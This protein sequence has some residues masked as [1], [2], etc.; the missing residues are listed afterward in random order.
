V[1]SDIRIAFRTL[2]YQSLSVAVPLHHLLFLPT[3]KAPFRTLIAARYI[4]M[5]LSYHT[6]AAKNGTK[7]EQ[8]VRE[9]VVDFQKKVIHK[10][11]Q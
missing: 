2:S 4:F 1:Y 6:L 5:L 11:N 10:Q 3:R 9:N 7:T 8:N